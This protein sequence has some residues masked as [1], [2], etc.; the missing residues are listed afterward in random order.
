MKTE[1]VEEETLFGKAGTIFHPFL[2]VNGYY[3]DNLFNTKE[4]EKDDYVTDIMPGIWIALPG[5]RQP[6]LSLNTLNTAPGGL[7][8]SRFKTAAERP[9]QGYALYRANI[10]R[11]D[12]FSEEDTENH[13]A[14]GLLRFRFR[15]DIEIEFA[16]IF[17]VEQDPYGTGTSTEMDEYTSNL[18][19]TMVTLPI[20]SKIALRADYSH[21]FLDYD[22]DRNG[23]RDRSDNAVSCYLFFK[24]FQKT[25]IFIEYEFVDIDYD[26]DILLDSQEHHYFFGIR[27]KYSDKT[28]ARFKIGYGL[29]D[30]DDDRVDD[31]DN[32]IGD[33]LLNFQS[34][35]KTRLYLQAYR[36][37]N[38][39]NTIIYRDMIS[40]RARLGYVQKLF[41]KCEAKA[42][43]GYSRDYYRGGGPGEKRKDD[44]IDAEVAL[45]YSPFKWLAVSAGYNFGS[46]NSNDDRYDYDTNTYFATITVAL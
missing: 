15:N 12:E 42:H 39:T 7:E 17:E 41:G 45:G 11:H 44:Y 6:L 34:S 9:F 31:P 21:Y 1:T 2:A 18:F 22:L 28:F 23:Y 38:E 8:I 16:D 35:E 5:S 10:R 19:N 14:E 30:Y 26:K 3:R 36:Q 13:R 33:F 25:S 24:I 29:K 32:L 40:N 46:R 37:V 4:D 43:V 20:T 27:W